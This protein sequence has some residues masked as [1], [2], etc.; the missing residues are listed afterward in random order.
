MRGGHKLRPRSVSHSNH[1]RTSSLRTRNLE[2]E[3]ALS[4]ILDLTKSAKDLNPEVSIL[5]QI[6]KLASGV[7]DN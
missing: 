7:L 4:S 5:S 3:N 2:L 1:I 6:H